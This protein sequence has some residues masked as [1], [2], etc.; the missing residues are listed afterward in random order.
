M[1]VESLKLGMEDKAGEVK[2]ILLRGRESKSEGLPF[3]LRILGEVLDLGLELGE[4]VRSYF[5]DLFKEIVKL[6]SDVW[7]ID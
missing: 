2:P 7:L 3:D 1:G 6:Y 4:K 5:I